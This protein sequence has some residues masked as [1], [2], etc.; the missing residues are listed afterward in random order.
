MMDSAQIL[1]NMQAS[2][3]HIYDVYN[4]KSILYALLSVYADRCG[5]R[6]QILTR[7]YGMIG[8]D[9]T[10]DEDLERRWGSLLGISRNNNESIEDYRTRLMMVYASLAGGTAEAIKYAIMSAISVSSDVANEYVKVYDAWLYDEYVTPH[11]DDPVYENVTNDDSAQ[12]NGG[13]ILNKNYDI[14]KYGAFVCTIDTS[15][16]EGIVTY[17][18][19]IMNTINM[20]KAS[21]TVPYLVFLHMAHEIT[22]IAPDDTICDIISADNIID[23][24]NINATDDNIDIYHINHMHESGSLPSTISGYSFTGTNIPDITLNN[25]FVTNMQTDIA[26]IC[27]DKIFINGESA[28]YLIYN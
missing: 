24:S 27:M 6:N 8:I 12:T 23:I 16:D 11:K 14:R 13:F 22:Q 3:P 21:G 19:K 25:K 5:R 4:E 7:L 2:F 20:T 18:D 10:Y 1:A 28:P 15:I 26:D 17:Y 9:T